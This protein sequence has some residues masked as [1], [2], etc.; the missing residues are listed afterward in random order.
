MKLSTLLPYMCDTVFVCHTLQLITDSDPAKEQ[1]PRYTKMFVDPCC[2]ATK[3][4]RKMMM[5]T[6]KTAYPRNAALSE[7][8]AA[9]ET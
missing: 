3:R 9:G 2:G 6:E 1:I 8:R 5:H 4:T 7:Q